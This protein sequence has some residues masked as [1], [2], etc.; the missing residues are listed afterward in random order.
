MKTMLP[1]ESKGGGEGE[2]VQDLEWGGGGRLSGAE[3]EFGGWREG[4]ENQTADSTG[5]V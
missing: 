2:A 5:G 4:L 1:L 3:A